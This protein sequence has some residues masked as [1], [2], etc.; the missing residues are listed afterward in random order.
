MQV[1]ISHNFTVL[2]SQLL[3]HISLCQSLYALIRCSLEPTYLPWLIAITKE[4]EMLLTVFTVFTIAQPQLISCMEMDSSS[5]LNSWFYDN[6]WMMAIFWVSLTSSCWALW[7]TK[8]SPE[9]AEEDNCAWCRRETIL[10][11]EVMVEPEDFPHPLPDVSPND[12]EPI[13]RGRAMC[14]CQ[15][16]PHTRRQPLEGAGR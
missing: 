10:C 3:A 13:T 15:C 4:C 5:A 1:Y 9:F 2:L 8:R 7:V 6:P 16:H 11:L 12:E 14:Q